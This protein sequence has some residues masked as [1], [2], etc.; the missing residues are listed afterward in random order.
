MILLYF[1]PKTYL[2]LKARLVPEETTLGGVRGRV[3][4]AEVYCVN[5]S[6][7]FGFKD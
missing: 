3:V 7:L 1:L 5:S 4:V 2:T 6:R